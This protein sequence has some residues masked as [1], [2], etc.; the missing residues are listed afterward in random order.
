MVA[1]DKRAVGG[2]QFIMY[3]GTSSLPNTEKI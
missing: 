2:V 3:G 1:Q